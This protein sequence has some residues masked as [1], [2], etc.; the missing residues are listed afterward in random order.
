MAVQ[1]SLLLIL[2]MFSILTDSL[3]YFRHTTFLSSRTLV[4]S[5]LSL[6]MYR[7]KA[8]IMTISRIKRL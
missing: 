4:S 5:V 1:L 6:Y 7:C 3:K 8:A 2:L